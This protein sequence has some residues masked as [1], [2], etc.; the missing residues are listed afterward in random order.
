MVNTVKSL[1][2]G[3][4]NLIYDFILFFAVVSFRLVNLL[5]Y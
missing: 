2:L 5:N 3:F 1:V 4:I